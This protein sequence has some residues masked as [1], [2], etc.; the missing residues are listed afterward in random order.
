MRVLGI[1]AAG[2]VLAASAT[3]GAEPMENHQVAVLQALDKVT[4]RV[5]A[6]E[7]PVGT[8]ARFGALSVVVRACKK[9]PPIE[10]PEAAAFLEI[11]EV[12][13]DE[14]PQAAFRGWMFASSPALSALE[15]PVYDIWVVDCH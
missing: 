12:R 9:N 11:D 5:R 10:A 7:V 2:V 1:L 13:P 8:A 4:A 6:L 3:A 15:H 14:P